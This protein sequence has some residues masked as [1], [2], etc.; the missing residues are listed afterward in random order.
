MFTYGNRLRSTHCFNPYIYLCQSL[1][2]FAIVIRKELEAMDADK[3][4][5]E[6]KEREQEEEEQ[7]KLIRSKVLYTQGGIMG[8]FLPPPP[9]K[10][11]IFHQFIQYDA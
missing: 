1:V 5:E 6:R 4:M 3:E 7:M 11:I 10:Q 8:V 9:L 2:T